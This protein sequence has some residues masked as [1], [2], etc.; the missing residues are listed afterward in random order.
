[1]ASP[2][3]ARTATQGGPDPDRQALRLGAGS[4]CRLRFHCRG[5]LRGS[6][7]E[8]ATVER[9]E[10]SRSPRDRVVARRRRDRK[11]ECVCRRSITLIGGDGIAEVATAAGA[12]AP[13]GPAGVEKR[14]QMRRRPQ[15]RAQQRAAGTNNTA[16]FDIVNMTTANGSLRAT[17]L[18]T[19]P[20]E[21]STRS[22]APAPPSRSP[23][24]HGRSSGSRR[25]RRRRR[26]GNRT[27]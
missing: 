5:R 11:K 7:S 13:R 22:S 19:R 26:R 6:V 12:E 2:A 16:L 3:A 25:N 18:R 17:R 1:M 9:R 14:K 24:P 8:I 4:R 10:R 15:T 27:R 20:R 21:L 23:G